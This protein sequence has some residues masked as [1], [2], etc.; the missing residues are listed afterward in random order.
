MSTAIVAPFLSLNGKGWGWVS[1]RFEINKNLIEKEFALEKNNS[2]LLLGLDG[3]ATKVSGYQVSVND[4]DLTF[5]LSANHAEK[6][7]SEI[8][9]YLPDFKAVD[10]STQLKQRDDHSMQLTGSEKQ[11]GAVYVESTAIVV[12]ELVQQSANN[13][14]LVGLGMPGLKTPDKRGIEVV[15]NGPR[16]LNYASLLEKRLELANIELIAPINQIGSDADY[17]GIGENYAKEGLFRDVENAYYLGGGTGVAD[18]LKLKGKLVFFDQIKPW[19]AKSWEM[20][21]EDGHSLERFAS[22]GG[23]QNLY[24][25]IAGKDVTDL[26]R[27]KIYPL[28]IAAMAAEGDEAARKTFDMVVKNLSLLLFER[29]STIYASWQGLFSFVNPNRPAL[30]TKHDYLGTLLDRI[31]IGQRLGELMDSEAGRTILRKPLIEQL[32]RLIASAGALDTTAKQHYENPENII[33]TSKLRAAP[34]LGAGIDA[35]LDYQSKK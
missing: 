6:A 23:I 4:S 8:P 28:Q 16:I 5:D 31:I 33:V 22:A 17:C 7:Y 15:A 11:Q 27:Q 35:Y 25:E 24:A 19:M 30:S 29:I 1:N 2:F 21:T 18:A 34:A 12:E 13:R 32:S 14:V 9:G 26:N 3:G 10:I 20:K